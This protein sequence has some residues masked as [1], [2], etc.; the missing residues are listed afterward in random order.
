M[1]TMGL[2]AVEAN[3][4]QRLAELSGG[5]GAGKQVWEQEYFGIFILFRPVQRSSWGRFLP[6][7]HSQ[8]HHGVGV[9][10]VL[11]PPG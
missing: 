3:T 9:L 1:M 6:M 2:S 10:V 7:L 4:F 11:T 5:Y 8:R